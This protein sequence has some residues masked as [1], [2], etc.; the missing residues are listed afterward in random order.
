MRALFC[1]GLFSAHHHDHH[2][3]HHDDHERTTMMQYKVTS[4]TTAN[5]PDHHDD[6]ESFV[7]R[8][9]AFVVKSECFVEFR[10]KYSKIVEHAPSVF[11]NKKLEV[12]DS[13]VLDK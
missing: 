12:P 4:N 9:E 2:D 6:H 11:V 7:A 8:F 3:D 13:V 1:L 5:H 10:G